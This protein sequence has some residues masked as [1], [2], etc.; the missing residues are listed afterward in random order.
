MENIYKNNSQGLMDMDS[1]SR[2]LNIKKS[3]LYQL[4]MKKQISVV[5]IGNLN[6]FRKGDLDTFICNNL[7]EAENPI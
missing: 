7:V 5:K 3:S 2:Y 1:A 4:C 6:K